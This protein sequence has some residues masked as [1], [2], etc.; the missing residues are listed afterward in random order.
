[1]IELRERNWEGLPLPVFTTG[2]PNPTRTNGEDPSTTPVATSL[3][4]PNRDLQ[5]HI[6]QSPPLESAATPDTDAVSGSPIQSPSISISTISDF[7][8]SDTSDDETPIDPTALVL[9]ETFYLHDGNVEVL[10]GNTLFRVHTSILSFQSPA[11]L[12]MFAQTN[13]ASADSPHGCPR[14]LSTDMATDFAILLKTV[15]LPG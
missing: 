6:P 13:L 2:G 15:Y 9:D 7:T 3:G 10:C 4:L 14:V 12:Q 1:M 5:P 8:I 11:L